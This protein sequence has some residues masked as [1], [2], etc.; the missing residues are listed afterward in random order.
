ML[1]KRL[2][3]QYRLHDRL[4]NGQSATSLWYSR[5]YGYGPTSSIGDF[6]LSNNP[7]LFSF[8]SAAAVLLI[9]AVLMYMKGQTSFFWGVS[10]LLVMFLIFGVVIWMTFTRQVGPQ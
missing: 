4:D 1:S 8:I 2:A 10:G 7:K 5:Q 9:L 3:N 6:H